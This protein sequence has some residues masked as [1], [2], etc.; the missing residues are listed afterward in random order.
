MSTAGPRY[1]EF[2][3]GVTR[4][5]LRTAG[6]VQYLRCDQDLTP[7]PSRMTDRL[8]AWAERT[9]QQTLFAQRDPQHRDTWQ[10]LSYA[11]ALANARAIGQALRD[12][13]L[14]A[15]RPLV[16]L[17]ENSLVH[18]QLA[19]GAMYAG[20]PFSAVSPAYALLSQDFD[21]LRHVFATLTPGL[22]YAA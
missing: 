6:D 5:V 3:F 12:R 2:R 16:I 8:I 17:S 21:K 18:A 22:V 19:L 13:G 7:Y 4:G 10:T 14:S 11:R 20:V 9:P 15:E 1:R